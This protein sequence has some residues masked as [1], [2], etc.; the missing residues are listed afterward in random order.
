MDPVVFRKPLGVLAVMAAALVVVGLI[1]P[2]PVSWVHV[3]VFL[4]IFGLLSWRQ[5]RS[6]WSWGSTR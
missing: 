1:S 3:G 5:R 6:H 2:W 4:F